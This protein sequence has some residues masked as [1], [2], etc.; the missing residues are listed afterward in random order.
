LEFLFESGDAPLSLVGFVAGAGLKGRRTVLE[1]LLMP[2]VKLAWSDAGF[3]QTVETGTFST[4]CRRRREAFSSGLKC[5]R[6]SVTSSPYLN[7][8]TLQFQLRQDNP[9]SASV[10]DRHP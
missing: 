4:G 7:G 8:T 2:L 3:S 10:I 5:F 9:A 6:C 1:E